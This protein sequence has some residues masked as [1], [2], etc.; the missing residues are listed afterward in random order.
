MTHD[1]KEVISGVVAEALANLAA[2]LGSDGDGES[3]HTK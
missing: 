3:R 2:V 1:L